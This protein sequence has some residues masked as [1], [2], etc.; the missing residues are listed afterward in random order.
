[1]DPGQWPL[2]NHRNAIFYLSGIDKDHLF[3]GHNSNK[4][5][6]FLINYYHYNDT[7]TFHPKAKLWPP[8]RLM[9]EAN[10]FGLE[11]SLYPRH[12]PNQQSEVKWYNKLIISK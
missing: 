5:G 6:G 11:T 9:R 3:W 12:K 2:A 8:K 10:S 4:N 1:M 7:Q